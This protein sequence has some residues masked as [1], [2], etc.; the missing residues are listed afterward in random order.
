MYSPAYS[1]YGSYGG[2]VGYSR[3]ASVYSSPY[4]G[5]QRYADYSSRNVSGTYSSYSPSPM[6][7]GSVAPGRGFSLPPSGSGL[8]DR[9]TRQRT[10]FRHSARD[11]VAATPENRNLRLRS[12]SIP[13]QRTR[14]ELIDSIVHTRTREHRAMPGFK[15]ASDYDERRSMRV[16]CDKVYDGI[17]LGNGDTICNISYLKGIGVTHVLNTAEKHV[18]VNPAKFGC[19]GI[20]YYGFHV[21]D[22]P[23]ANISRYFH[24]TTAFI[25]KAVSTG[26]LVL[27]NCYMGWS[28][29]AT[30]VAAYLMM[31][32]NMKATKALELI[33]Q[34]RSIRPNAGFLQQLADLENTLSKRIAW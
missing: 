5:H 10:V 19:Y 25:D 24:T 29:S 22:L 16:D 3:A 14:D 6:S 31:K 11:E 13:R 8:L 20:Q 12:P 32:H 9:A 18:E 1:S 2:G 26:G 4:G 21:D 30:C 7:R 17:I 27:V 33:R 28:R 23:E 15:S 34:N